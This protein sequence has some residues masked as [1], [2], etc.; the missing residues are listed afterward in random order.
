[1]ARTTNPTTLKIVRNDIT[2]I[3]VNLVNRTG[4]KDK[5]A[6]TLITDSNGTTLTIHEKL[7][8]LANIID[9]IDSTDSIRIILKIVKMIDEV[10]AVQSAQPA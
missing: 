1:M 4:C 2:G 3:I 5:M 8:H 7:D 6:E 9:I 10:L